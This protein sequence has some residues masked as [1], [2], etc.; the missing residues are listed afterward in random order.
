MFSTHAENSAD[1]LNLKLERGTEMP[2]PIILDGGAR[3][4][5]IELPSSFTKDEQSGKFSV[6]PDPDNEHFQSIVIKDEKGRPVFTQA[7][8]NIEERWTIEIK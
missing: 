4:I 6:S 5:T 7:I 2:Q 8:N 3:M 1:Y